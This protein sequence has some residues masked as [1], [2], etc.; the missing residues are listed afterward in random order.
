MKG[1]NG[2]LRGVPFGRPYAYRAGLSAEEA[3]RLEAERLRL[4]QAAGYMPRA[5]DWTP[6]VPDR[7][8]SCGYL[9]TAPGHLM[10]CGEVRR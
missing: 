6:P 10:A 8:G 5:Q 7:C 4:D 2:G 3:A 9:V 1:S